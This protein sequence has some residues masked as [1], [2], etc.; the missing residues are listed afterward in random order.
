M[1][2]P[3]WWRFLGLGA[4]ALV[5][6]WLEPGAG[7]GV[8]ASKRALASQAEAAESGAQIRVTDGPG[9][10]AA[11]LSR[12]EAAAVAGAHLGV[13]GEAGGGDSRGHQSNMR[14]GT[15]SAV[16]LS[17]FLSTCNSLWGGTG[18]LGASRGVVALEA[19]EGE[20]NSQ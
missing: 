6:T 19:R 7:E 18:G 15:H 16:G 1:R 9:E 3:D 10:E 20:R 14:G 12:A 2:K 17:S 8:L 5:G 13:A 4:G 11:A